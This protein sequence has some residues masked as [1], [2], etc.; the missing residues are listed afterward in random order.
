MATHAPSL[1]EDAPPPLRRGRLRRLLVRYRARLL[2]GFAVAGALAV[3]V[4]R[5]RQAGQEE[6]Q[7]IA[8]MPDAERRALYEQVLRSAELLCARARTN[9]ALLDRCTDSAT[10]LLTFPE[11]D[12]GC[13][14]L[15]RIHHR[16]ATR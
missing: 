3:A 16:G 11:C 1:M 4:V 2:V 6:R 10:F 9:D 12:D 5:Q 14:Q 8:T 7:A 13:R 15:S